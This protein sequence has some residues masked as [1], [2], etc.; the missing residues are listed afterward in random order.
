METPNTPT[1]KTEAPIRPFYRALRTFAI[2][3]GFSL[4]LGLAALASLSFGKGDSA[5]LD[6]FVLIFLAIA[7][8]VGACILALVMSAIVLIKGISAPTQNNDIEE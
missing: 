2:G 1:E 5:G 8:F 7:V 3:S 6:F 4:L